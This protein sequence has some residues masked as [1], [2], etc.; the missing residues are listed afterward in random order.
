MPKRTNTFQQVIYMIQRQ[1]AGT[2]AVVTESKFLEH[3][4]TGNAAEVDVV[5]EGKLAGQDVTL[6][7]ECTAGKRPATI[8]WVQQMIGKHQGMPI[9]RSILVSQSGFTR[10]AKKHA[11]ECVK[12]FET[13]V[14]GN[15]VSNAV[16][17]L[18]RAALVWAS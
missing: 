14:E 16:A 18:G 9:S 13:P 17:P 2:N 10:N 6:G 4:H 5:I 3:R 7:I 12:N 11:A 1:L 15:L 8:E